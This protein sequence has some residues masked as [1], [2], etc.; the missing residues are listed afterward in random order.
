MNTETAAS[1]PGDLIDTLLELSPDG[2]RHTRSKVLAATQG[3]YDLFFDPALAGG[4]S[5]QERLLVALHACH[6]TPQPLL[7]EHYQQQLQ[8]L[9]DAELGV[10]AVLANDLSGLPTRLAA[11]LRFTGTL[12]EAPVEGDR[13][14]LER[15]HEAGLSTPE[16][17]T[18]A[19]LVAFLSYQVRLA[20]GLLALNAAGA[21]P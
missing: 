2:V 16:I 10:Q 6:L 1:P 15:L 19:Q 8:A 21:A 17:V 4:L 5:L 7:S 20:A 18:L 13:Q 14:A 9:G 11:I 12:I 3:S